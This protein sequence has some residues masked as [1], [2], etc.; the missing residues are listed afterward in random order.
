M[1]YPVIVECRLVIRQTLQFPD[2]EIDS[3][4][5]LILDLRTATVNRNSLA[6]ERG[7]NG[8]D[9]RAK[10]RKPDPPKIEIVPSASVEQRREFDSNP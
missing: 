6:W 1:A 4:G 3:E 5:I 8:N 7:R 2:A 10:R 9:R